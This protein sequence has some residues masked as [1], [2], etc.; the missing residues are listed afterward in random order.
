MEDL[1][2]AATVLLTEMRKNKSDKILQNRL[3]MSLRG[4][5][6]AVAE[7]RMEYWKEVTKQLTRK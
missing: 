1:R 6:I 2:K 7:G 4:M 5:E 3:S